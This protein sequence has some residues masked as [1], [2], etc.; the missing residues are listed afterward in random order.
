[1]GQA[2]VLSHLPGTLGW[3]SIPTALFQQH[4]VRVTL[5]G[6]DGREEGPDGGVGLSDHGCE[7]AVEGLS[8][9]V[10][11]VEVAGRPV[12]EIPGQGR[13]TSRFGAADSGDPLN[14]CCHEVVQEVVQAKVRGYE[15][16]EVH[17]GGDHLV[18]REEGQLHQPPDPHTHRT[19]SPGLGEG[20]VGSLV[21]GL[22]ESVLSHPP[23]HGLAEVE[24]AP[25]NHRGR[26]YLGEG[27]P[28]RLLEVHHDGLRG[29][30]E[31]RVEEDEILQ[32]GVGILVG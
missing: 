3:R 22:L 26:E 23:Q 30:V 2:A 6:I 14:P 18:D 19:R 9:I 29:E 10:S 5:L 8:V 24:E 25:I 32:V 17:E 12:N 4:L 27:V 20:V 11:L 31:E 15:V 16:Q 13:E 21:V 28:K 7:L 1:M